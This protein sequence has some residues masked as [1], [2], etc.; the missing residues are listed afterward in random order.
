MKRKL[1]LPLIFALTLGLAGCGGT[2]PQPTENSSPAPISSAAASD[3]ASSQA[4]SSQPTEEEG[5][6]VTAQ[7]KTQ[8]AGCYDDEYGD[9]YTLN[10]DGTV[11]RQQADQEETSGSWWV[12]QEKGTDYLYIYMKETAH[13]AAYTFDVAE[14]GGISLFD[15]TTGELSNLFTP[16]I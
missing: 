14:D 3:P 6:D 15:D 11:L 4:A 8:L 16:A 12:W 13:P 1:I 7:Y 9:R 5:K 10:E 2:A